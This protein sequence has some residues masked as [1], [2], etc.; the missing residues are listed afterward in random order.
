MEDM[1]TWFANTSASNASTANP[2]Y[3]NTGINVAAA[4][5]AAAVPTTDMNGGPV[6]GPFPRPPPHPPTQ[7]NPPGNGSVSQNQGF[8]ALGMQGFPSYD[9]GSWYEYQ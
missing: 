7:G 3:S 6:G 1:A 9:E 8:S 2:A 5:A 4:A